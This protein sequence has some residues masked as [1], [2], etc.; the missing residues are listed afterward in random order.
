[1]SWERVSG[2]KVRSGSFSVWKKNKGK[3]ASSGEITTSFFVIEFS[4]NMNAKDLFE[5]FKVYGV[6][7]EVFISA[8]RDKRGNRFGFAKFRK[9]HDP[10]ILACNLDS[11][12]LE[13]KKIYVNIPRFSKENKRHL[14]VSEKNKRHLPDC[15]N[16]RSNIQTGCTRNFLKPNI[17][18]R[19][20][21]KV[22]RGDYPKFVDRAKVGGQCTKHKLDDEWSRR[23]NRM[24]V[25]EVM[26]DGNAFN[27][28]KLI[29]EEGY[30]NIKATP[31]GASLCLLEDTSGG[32]LEGFIKEARVWLDI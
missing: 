30:F 31:L 25:G 29:F 21:A 20:F 22:V 4:E 12:V 15:E 26:K 19:S 24:R 1:M 2:R 16:L 13:G 18:V 9:V 6:I 5:V 17:Q 27:I 23:L 32:D 28:Q 3:G 14:P 8:K 7:S 10:R 11:I